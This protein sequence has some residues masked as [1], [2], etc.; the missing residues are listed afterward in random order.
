[1][2]G[3]GGRFPERLSPPNARVAERMLLSAGLAGA[4]GLARQLSVSEAVETV[5]GCPG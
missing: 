5:E 1:M 2:R 4:A 3:G